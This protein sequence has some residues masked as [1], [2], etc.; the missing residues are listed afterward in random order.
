MLSLFRE[1][2]SPS[3]RPIVLFATFIRLVQEGRRSASL[4]RWE[5]VLPAISS[6]KEISRLKAGA[7][8]TESILQEG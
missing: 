5:V 8:I 1:L 2:I 7:S 6:Q 3:M 4:V